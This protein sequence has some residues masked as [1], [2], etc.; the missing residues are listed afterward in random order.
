MAGALFTPAAEHENAG[1]GARLGF[2]PWLWSPGFDGLVF[3]G[4]AGLALLLVALG[5]VLGFGGGELPEWGFVAFILCVDVAHVYSTLFRTYFDGQEIRTHRLR[6]FGVPICAYGVGVGLYLSGPL[7]FWRILAYL[8]VFH[9]VRQQ[10]GWVSVY[11][12]RA[13]NSQ[14]LDA[15]LDGA[16]TYAAALYPLLEWHAHLDRTRF[17]WFVRGDFV[18]VSAWAAQALPFARVAWLALLVAFSC[19]QLQ[20]AIKTRIVQLGKILIV[21]TTAAIWY[22][23]IVATNSDFDFTI[24]NVVAHGVP[25]LALLYRYGRE[26]RRDQPQALGSG[27]LAGGLLA[28]LA[29]IVALAFVEELVWDRWIWKE[30]AWLFGTSERELTNLA[31]A[32]LVPLLALPQTVHYLL[33]GFLWRRADTRR[34][35]AQRRALGFEA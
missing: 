26:R 33:D 23:G 9:F 4:S 19:R 35:A 27:L 7:N 16:A 3:A 29:S 15:V 31:L 17:D 11:R 22:I 13:G 6:Y 32:A 20:L 12:A 25:Y 30:R 28:F 5:R 10:V 14:R 24:T 34:I 8:A 18:D 1:S 2:G 21:G